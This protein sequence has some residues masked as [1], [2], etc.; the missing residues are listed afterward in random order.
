MMEVSLVKIQ[1]T[2]VFKY[3]YGTTD[4]GFC[5]YLLCEV[6]EP[7]QKEARFLADAICAERGGIRGGVELQ[8]A[9]W[10]VDAFIKNE[11]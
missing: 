6:G 10:C 8:N 3:E 1:N 2:T 5:F 4:F 11:K 7:Y 9:P